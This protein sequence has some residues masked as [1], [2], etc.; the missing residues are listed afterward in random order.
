MNEVRYDIDGIIEFARDSKM[1]ISPDDR[2]DWAMFC[3]ALKVLGYDLQTFFE[4]SHADIKTCREYWRKEKNPESYFN[5]DKAK[6]CIVNRAKKA[7]MD[8]ARFRIESGANSNLEDSE[9]PR[10][11]RFDDIEIPGDGQAVKVNAGTPGD[12]PDPAFVYIEPET[13]TGLQAAVSESNLHK[14]VCSLFPLDE[15]NRVFGQYRIGTI[16]VRGKMWSTFPVINCNGDCVDVHM[17]PYDETGHRVKEKY[18]QDWLLRKQGEKD[19]RAPWPLFG[20]HLLADAGNK[21][22]GI[23]ESEKTALLSALVAPDFIWMATLS[24]SNLTANRCSAIRDRDCYLFPDNDGLEE[25]M[26]KGMAMA[27]G[28][29][30]LYFAGDI[31]A[32]YALGNKDDLGDIIVRCR[33]GLEA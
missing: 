8:L 24:M 19:S 11:N 17:M 28:G 5:I 2:K 3:C 4:L 7:G 10:T 32:R 14:F 1:D 21:P 25:W 20:E 13:L 33:K 15:V 30:N 26:K 18:S 6:G 16:E 29:F 27:G 31:I 9:C 22:V 23:V 12:D